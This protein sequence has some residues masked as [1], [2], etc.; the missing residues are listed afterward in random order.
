MILS[1]L[2]GR[3]A[4]PLDDAPRTPVNLYKLTRLTGRF[5]LP[6]DDAP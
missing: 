4:L 3:F 6:I 5:V 1:R 2:T